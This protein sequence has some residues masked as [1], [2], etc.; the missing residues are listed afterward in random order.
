MLIRPALY[1]IRLPRVHIM[2]S[3][4]QHRVYKGV[5]ALGSSTVTNNCGMI[6][7]SPAER[8][9]HTAPQSVRHSLLFQAL[10]LC[11]VE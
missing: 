7:A 9:T 2:K 5:C 6:P 8:G 4:I 11:R 10:L 3:A 1:Q